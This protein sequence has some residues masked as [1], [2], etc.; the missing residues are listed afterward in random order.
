MATGRPRGVRAHPPRVHVILVEPLALVR[1]GLERLIVDRSEF[2]L[3]RATGDVDEALDAARGAPNRTVAVVGLG[4]DGPRDWQWVIRAIKDHHPSVAVLAC[5][6]RSDAMAVSLALFAGAD[7]FVDKVVEPEEFHDALVR[8]SEGEMVLA[9]PPAEWVG[10]IAGGLER[11]RVVGASLTEREREVLDVAAEGL[12]A[13]EIADRLGVAERTITTHLSRIYMKLGVG[14][15]LRAVR[16]ATRSG[17]L[18]QR[19][20]E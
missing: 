2:E 7:G 16:E 13:R 17:L 6:A 12:T 5:G 20:V 11:R 3:R 10:T 9:G 8:A 1:V 4:L 14:G 19:S 15:R 18:L